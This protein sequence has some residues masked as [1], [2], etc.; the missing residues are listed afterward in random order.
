MGSWSKGAKNGQ[1]VVHPFYG[2]LL[3]G[4]PVLH[5]YPRPVFLKLVPQHTKN[6]RCA[7]DG[8]G[9]GELAQAIAQSGPPKSPR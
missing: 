5:P 7:V 3:K 1:K 8:V 6:C 2:M 4:G 9:R